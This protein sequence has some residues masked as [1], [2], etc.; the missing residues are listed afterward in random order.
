MKYTYTL[1]QLRDTGEAAGLL[2]M[3][4]EYVKAHGGIRPELYFTAA[5][6]TIEAISQEEACE[7]LYR[8]YNMER[9]ADYRGRSMSVSDIVNLWDNE[10]EPPVKT[11]WFCDSIGFKQ[12]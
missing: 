1:D 3:N 2:F 12:I 11:S 10:V 9:P 6:G 7:E 8:R 4:S 5:H